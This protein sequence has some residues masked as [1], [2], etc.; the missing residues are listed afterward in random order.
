MK[1]TKCGADCDPR[2][3]FCLRCGTPLNAG[4]SEDEV[5]K[6]VEVPIEDMV[7]AISLEEDDDDI[8][9]IIGR[10]LTL[11]KSNEPVRKNSANVAKNS[12]AP[13]TNKSSFEA[14]HRP[15][16]N[17]TE[18]NR[19]SENDKKK[20]IIG[21]SVAGVVLIIIIVVLIFVFGGSG[22]FDDYYQN[23]MNLYNKG[24]VQDSIVQFEN[25]ADVADND[26]EK[27]DV[28]VM[29]WK[30]YSQVD[31]YEKDEIDVLMKL[32]NIEPDNGTYYEALITLYRDLNDQASIDKL[33]ENVNDSELK[34][35]LLEFDGTTPVATIEAGEYDKPISVGLT[36]AAD[37]TIHY[38]INGGDATSSS[39]VYTSSIEFNEE[40]EYIIKAVGIDSE[41]NVSKQFE[42]KYILNFGTVNPPEVDLASGTY[43]ERKKVTVTADEGC[44]I[45]Y[46]TDGSIPTEDS[47]EY[48]K[49]FKIPEANRIYYF[50]AIDEKGIASEVVTRVY[51]FERVYT[52]D[53]NTAVSGLTD[54]L[55]SK[56]I[57]ENEIGIYEDGS[58]MYLEYETVEKIDDEYYYIIKA[59]KESEE[60]NT[61][62]TETYAF[63]CDNGMSYKAKLTGGEYELSEI[64]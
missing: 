62:F 25:A 23:G 14:N 48:K 47:K 34:D 35:R 17:K 29:L 9:F 1:C 24:R 40:G 50:I 3:L 32:I 37:S 51:N 20:M 64:D 19:K 21:I 8:D 27:K 13:K 26:E 28:Y 61:V 31:G 38:T 16:N 11:R 63:G 6:E 15:D 7:D 56:G 49:P 30:A 60:G 36:A 39:D 57:M 5:I 12:S 58:A 4:K 42:G 18:N 44:K 45:Y 10:D 59:T 33:I 53:Y 43:N 54:V 41:G 2:Q 22:K 52:N 55:I 46:T